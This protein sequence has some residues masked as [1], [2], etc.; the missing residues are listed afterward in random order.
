MDSTTL[1]IKEIQIKTPL[2]LHL[3]QLEW[4]Y[5]RIKTTTNA[6][7]NAAKQEPLY[8]VGGNAN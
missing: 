4:L 7:K 3:T 6:G 5:S 8:T 2:R 1:A